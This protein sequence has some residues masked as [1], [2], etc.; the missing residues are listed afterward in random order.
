VRH[1]SK[2]RQGERHP[3]PAKTRRNAEPLARPGPDVVEEREADVHQAGAPGGLPV[4]HAVFGLDGRCPS[5]EPCFERAQQVR[6]DGGIRV[7]DHDRVGDRVCL[8]SLEPERKGVPLAALGLVGANE[9]GGARLG[10]SL[11][12]RVGAV[13]RDDDHA[14]E[15]SGVIHGQQTLHGRGDPRLLVMRGDD[16]VEAQPRRPVGVRRHHRP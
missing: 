14:P 16:E 8:R 11:R 15:F 4:G 3:V 2:H 9:D 10:G 5:T 13:V 6:S 7:D 1:L 12:R